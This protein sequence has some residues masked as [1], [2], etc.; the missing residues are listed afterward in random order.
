MTG[1][2]YVP[3][4][5]AFIIYRIHFGNVIYVVLGV[6]LTV[7]ADRVPNF[8]EYRVF[9]AVFAEYRVSIGLPSI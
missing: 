4:I 3:L 5:H 6:F 7:R 8:A 1:T 2:S 9:E